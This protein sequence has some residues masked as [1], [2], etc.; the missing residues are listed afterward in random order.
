MDI[1][2]TIALRR[3]VNQH[4]AAPTIT[5]PAELVRALG[6]VQ[7][8]DYSGAKWGIGL[9]TRGVTDADVER[10]M[11]DGSI[12]RTH[13]LRPTWHFVAPADIRWMLALTAPRVKAATASY[14]RKLGLDD[15]IFRRTNAALTRALRDGTRLTRTE[16]AHALRRARVDATGTQRLA[17]L[18]MRAELDGVVCSGGRRGKQFTYAL[19]EERVPPAAPL[20]RDEALLELTK[21]YFATRSPATAR[22]F[23]WWSGLTVGD[24]TRGIQMAGPS[25]ERE[26]VGDRAY[27][28]DPSLRARSTTPPTAHLLPN[29]DEYFIGFRDRGAIGR[30]LQSVDLVTGGDALTAYVVAVDGQLV[31][32]WKR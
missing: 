7:A 14:D 32:G 2:R 10:A 15:S 4:L 28:V 12:V 19:L 16:L 23:A 13:V 5:T 17:H 30:R 29:Y 21:R 27:W 8:Q 1:E 20:D 25:L 31:G 11:T 18:V 26:V 9:R 3:L 22:D 24:A 6:A